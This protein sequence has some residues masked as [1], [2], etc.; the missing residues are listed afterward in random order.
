MDVALKGVERIQAHAVRSSHARARCSAQRALRCARCALASHCVQHRAS[1]S[2]RGAS[3]C[4]ALTPCS[5]IALRS[6][7]AWRPTPPSAITVVALTIATATFAGTAAVIATIAIAVIATNTTP[8]PHA[9]GAN[10][11]ESCVCVWIGIPRACP[12]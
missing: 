6:G 3:L 1:C 9:P 7:G 5:L 8:K 10:K 12:I 11:C 2:I 4:C